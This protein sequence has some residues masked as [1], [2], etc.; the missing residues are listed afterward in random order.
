MAA[1][2]ASLL[3]FI[4]VSLLLGGVISVNP[5][6]LQ[7][8]SL[9]TGASSD[10]AALEESR[11]ASIDSKAAVQMKQDKGQSIV[12]RQSLSFSEKQHAASEAPFCDSTCVNYPQCLDT[13]T[14]YCCQ[15]TGL[16]MEQAE[17]EAE[18]FTKMEEE[19]E[20]EAG[21][22]T[23]QP[24]STEAEDTIESKETKA[25]TMA[26]ISI[27]II[28]SACSMS[29]SLMMKRRAEKDLADFKKQMDE[30]TGQPHRNLV[31]FDPTHLDHSRCSSSVVSSSRCWPSLAAL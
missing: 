30:G 5:S 29:A 26:A 12:R 14:E 31:H 25:L 2:S 17:E 20:R 23:T 22:T 7:S 8:E 6:P 21:I 18:K 4:V 27:V 24:K 9:K 13:C 11:H 16:T 15:K 1:S 19:A 28:F 10:S 3:R